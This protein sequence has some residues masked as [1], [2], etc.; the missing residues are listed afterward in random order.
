M[1]RKELK[2]YLLRFRNATIIAAAAASTVIS[3]GAMTKVKL[4]SI[5][6]DYRP[7]AGV[8]MPEPVSMQGFTFEVSKETQRARVVVDYTYP[9]QVAFGADGGH[10][11]EPTIVQVP[12]LKYDPESNAVVYDTGGAKTVCATVHQRKFLF[13][14]TVSVAP[15]GSCVV[16]SA[17]TDHTRDNGWSISH[18]RT[19]DTYLEVR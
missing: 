13:W 9:D 10:G 8:E 3:A 16:T 11:P 4:D 1:S 6:P 19:I 7:T 5:S 14:K 17:L 15:T 18:I 12:G 2:M